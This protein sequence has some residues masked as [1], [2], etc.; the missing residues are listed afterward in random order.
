[1]LL[2]N[3]VRAYAIVWGAKL[4]PAINAVIL[5]NRK[6]TR[7]WSGAQAHD[8][9]KRELESRDKSTIQGTTGNP[10]TAQG[11]ARIVHTN[12]DLHKVKDGDI[13]VVHMTRQDFVP[14]MR[15]CIAIVADEGGVICHAAIL[16][17]ELGLPCIVGAKNATRALKDGQKV[18]VD[19]TKGTVETVA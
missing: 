2:K 17:R 9:G 3:N 16:A 8:L 4:L 7:I 19:A 10:G 18:K 11:V 5:K 1:M 15:R 6:G 12:Q 14:A 13:L